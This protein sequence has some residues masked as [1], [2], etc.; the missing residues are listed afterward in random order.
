M[1]KAGEISI[2]NLAHFFLHLKSLRSNPIQSN[3]AIQILKENNIK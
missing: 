2:A 3:Y 1:K